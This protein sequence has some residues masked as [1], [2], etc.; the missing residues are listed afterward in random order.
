MALAV[1][2]DAIGEGTQAP[3]FLLLDL[4][5][6][7]FDD[8][9][10]VGRECVHLLRADVLARDQEMLIESHVR[11]FVGLR[12][13]RAREPAS[14]SDRWDAGRSDIAPIG[15][16]RRPQPPRGGRIADGAGKGKRADKPATVAPLVSGPLTG[17]TNIP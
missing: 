4:A 7:A 5:V 16:P 12:T 11:P 3:I 1:F 2:L 8:G 14:G 10:E 9:L 6:L 15:T 17:R 13:E